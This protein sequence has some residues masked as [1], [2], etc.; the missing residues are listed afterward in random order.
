MLNRPGGE[1]RQATDWDSY[2]RSI[3]F[4]ANLTRR[5]STAAL[6]E[7]MKRH[8]G[9]PAPNKGLCI[10]EMGGANSCFID[11]IL[12]AIP[13]SAYHVI[14]TN[15]FGL[16]LLQ[17][18]LGSRDNVRLHRASVLDIPLNI[19]ADIVFSVGLVEHFDAGDTRKAILA[20]FRLLPAGGIAIINFPTPTVL[21]RAARTAITA[22][23][24]WEFPDE[25]ALLPSEVL[26]TIIEQGEVLQQRTLWPL[27]LTQHMVVARKVR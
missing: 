5:Y 9:A 24:M 22:L 17:K 18:R 14:D 20:H 8:G 15:Q 4:T 26:G 7:A 11:S 6:L 21:Y 3:P 2:Y 19:Q 10:V 23:G 13:C 1:A 25:R 27:I 16:S 12:S